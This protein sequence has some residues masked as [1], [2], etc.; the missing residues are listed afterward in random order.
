LAVVG[1]NATNP[2][3]AIAGL[4]QLDKAA[5]KIESRG[6]GPN[7]AG[8]GTGGANGGSA[9]H[10]IGDKHTFPNGNEGAW[11]GV[12]WRVTKLAKAAQ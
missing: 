4:E 12:G 3:A 6:I 9:K 10:K 2:A 5:A 7:A 1:K 11:D 8:S